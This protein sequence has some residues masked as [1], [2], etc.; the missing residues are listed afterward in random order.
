M[1][2]SLSGLPLPQLQHLFA[3]Y[4]EQGTEL[5]LVGGCV[6]DTILAKP[7]LDVD[8]AT[9]LPPDQGMTLLRNRKI[10]VIATGIEHGTFTAVIDHYPFQITTLRK[11]VKTYGRHA[12]V[13]FGTDWHEDAQRRDFTINA[14]YADL[15]GNVFD[16][17]RGLE[18]LSV[19]II[20]FIGDPGKRI[21][22]DY[23]RI[24]RFF[25]FY[26]WYGKQ[27]ACPETLNTIAMHKI[28]LQQIARERIHMEF[29]KLLK[30]DMPKHTLDLIEDYGISPFITTLPFH[31]SRVP[32]KEALSPE[33]RLYALCVQHLEDIKVLNQ[34]LR[35]ANKQQNYLK[36][37]AKV[38]ANIP[39]ESLFFLAYCY[40]PEA[41]YEALL[42][43]DREEEANLIKNLQIPPFP[44]K[45]TDI[46]LPP[47][48][49]LGLILQECTRWWCN[50]AYRPNKQDCRNW[51]KNYLET[52]SR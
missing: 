50:Q 28:G 52:S 45:G 11:D 10:P 42:I 48:P 12:D 6:R 7:V 26:A 30:A 16:Y 21:Q 5:R 36:A 9:P 38:I 49:E 2:I 17:H 27:K 40:S 3:I 32:W 15:D 14:L 51:V 35:L 34:D 4:H 25:R 47:G 20:R 23:L 37:L 22:E 33:A 13:I 39:T 31:I 41:T 18:D 19:G 44:L 24:L 46:P 43:S 8:L 1:K 29:L